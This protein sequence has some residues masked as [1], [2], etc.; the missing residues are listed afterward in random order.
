MTTKKSKTTIGDKKNDYKDTLTSYK[1]NG[2]P[3]GRCNFT[4]LH[5]VP[6]LN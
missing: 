4:K 6:V 5:H 3:V 1:F 2:M